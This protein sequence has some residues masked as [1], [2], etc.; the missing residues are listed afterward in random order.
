MDV[1]KIELATRHK[2]ERD[3][4]YGAPDR[5][6]EVRLPAVQCRAGVV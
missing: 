4:R 2:A 3:A 1:E 6:T 5:V